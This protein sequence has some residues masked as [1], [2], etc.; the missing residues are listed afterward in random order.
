MMDGKTTKAPGERVQHAPPKTKPQ[1]RPGSA[2]TGARQMQILQ[3]TADA[4]S[5][6]RT[7][8]QLKKLAYLRPNAGALRQLS[9]D[10]RLRLQLMRFGGR[11]EV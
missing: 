11:H 2:S 9:G 8:R 4:S 5:H 6:V 1:P 3:A 10:E 7:L